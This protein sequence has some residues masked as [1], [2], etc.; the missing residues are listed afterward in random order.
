[1][2]FHLDPERH[3]D[4][5]DERDKL[6]A[7]EHGSPNQFQ[8][9]QTYVWPSVG[10]VIQDKEFE[11]KIKSFFTPKVV[12]IIFFLTRIEFEIIFRGI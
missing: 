5:T 7:Q 6:R 10:P 2:T 3:K 12:S 4:F 8:R 1:M 11:S 9:S